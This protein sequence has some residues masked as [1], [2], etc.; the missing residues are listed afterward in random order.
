MTSS[1]AH[2]S[3]TRYLVVFAVLLLAAAF[4]LPSLFIAP[5]D[6]SRGMPG[7]TAVDTK[8]TSVRH[9]PAP[10]AQSIPVP[11]LSPTPSS[12]PASSAS[13]SPE[14]SQTSSTSVSHS[15]SRSRSAS[16]SV[17]LTSSVSY[18]TSPSPPPPAIP[19][20]IPSQSPLPDASVSPSASLS[21]SSSASVSVSP[22]PPKPRPLLL[23]AINFYALALGDLFIN[24]PI[25]RMLFAIMGVEVVMNWDRPLGTLPSTLHDSLRRMHSARF[26][27]VQTK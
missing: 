4:W 24:K 5:L 13:P 6:E 3:K 23:R 25:F 27:H 17:S 1:D 9:I 10:P 15:S 2:C 18:S 7:L 20:S 21:S 8:G 11:A 26:A 19:E 16:A 22:L 14:P 12:T